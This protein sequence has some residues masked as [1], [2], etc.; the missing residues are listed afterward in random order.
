MINQWLETL[1]TFIQDSTWLAP[2]IALLAGILTSLTPCSLSTIPLIVGYVGG[3]SKETK[4]AFKLSLTFAIGSAITFTVL[5]VIASIAG[6]LIGSSASWW[7]ILIGILMILM[8]LQI[9]EL[10]QFIPSTNIMSKSK[11]TGYIGAF[12]AGILG[13]VFSSPCATP[14]LIVLLALV[15]GQGSILWGTFLLL[16]YSI[17]H[18]MLAI[19]AGT[20]VGFANKITTDEKYSKF[21]SAIKIIMG[22]MILLI[23]LYM[24]YLGF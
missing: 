5:G 14:V 7:Y 17:G 22:I 12:V 20:S 1:S 19:I 16:L 9:W 24:I 6:G 11:K 13:G 15:A 3:T 21:S 10:Y 18:G 8:A 23:G 4:K 2:V